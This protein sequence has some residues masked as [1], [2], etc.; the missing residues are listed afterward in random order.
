MWSD[1]CEAKKFKYTCDN[2]VMWLQT[3]I[4][5]IWQQNASGFRRY[6][7]YPREV[8]APA[9][10]RWDNIPR[11]GCGIFTYSRESFRFSHCMSHMSHTR[12]TIEHSCYELFQT[13]LVIY[14]HYFTVHFQLLFLYISYLQRKQLPTWH[15]PPLKPFHSLVCK[16]DR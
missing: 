6:G 3:G 14:N 11:A 8:T 12:I 4:L 9:V 7:N 10:I 1:K 16:G 5:K 15:S 13:F 2:T